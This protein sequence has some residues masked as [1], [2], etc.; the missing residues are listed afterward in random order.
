MAESSECGSA[1]SLQSLSNA[2]QIS[3]E[4]EQLEIKKSLSHRSSKASIE[5]IKKLSSLSE[6]SNILPSHLDYKSGAVYEGK[7]KDNLKFGQGIF[8][9]PNGDK[10]MGE[11]RSNHRHGFGK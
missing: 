4:N 8:I 5:K 2:Q 6:N 10:Y 11:F 3:D 9:W 7:I 1:C